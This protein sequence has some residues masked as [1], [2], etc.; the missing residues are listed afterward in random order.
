MSSHIVTWALTLTLLF[1]CSAVWGCTQPELTVYESE[2]Y[3]GDYVEIARRFDSRSNVPDI[4]AYGMKNY[5]LY[6]CQEGVWLAYPQVNYTGFPYIWDEDTCSGAGSSSS[7]LSAHIVGDPLNFTRS[8]L[9]TFPAYHYQDGQETY[10]AESPRFASPI[11]SLILM[12]S[13]SVELFTGAGHTGL[14]ICIRPHMGQIFDYSELVNPNNPQRSR[15]TFVMDLV[16]T[17]GLP[18]GSINSFTFGCRNLGLGSKD[19]IPPPLDSAARMA[20]AKD[21]LG[22]RRRQ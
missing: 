3:A 15:G 14:S 2:G 6:H 8:T 7:W 21:F 17:L 5:R 20:S 18:A 1:A 9:N 13:S 22:Q 16:R 4:S 10:Y 19:L 11:T 12:G